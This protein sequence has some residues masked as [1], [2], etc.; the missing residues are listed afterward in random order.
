MSLLDV[1]NLIVNLPTAA[2]W[3]RPVNEVSI[4]VTSGDPPPSRVAEISLAFRRNAG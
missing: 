1:R 2:G 4:G 3:I